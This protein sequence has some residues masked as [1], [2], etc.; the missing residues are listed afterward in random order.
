MRP[1]K[2]AQI[3]LPTFP[4]LTKMLG[5]NLCPTKTSTGVDKN[6]SKGSTPKTGAY[7]YKKV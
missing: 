5:P 1:N 7:L 4:T 6:A 2:T 3:L